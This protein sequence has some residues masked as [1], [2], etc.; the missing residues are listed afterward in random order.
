MTGNK[1]ARA[2]VSALCLALALCFTAALTANAL[3][4]DVPRQPAAVFA[5]REVSGDTPIPSGARDN[6]RRFSLEL[7]FSATSS[8]NVQ[9]AFGRDAE[10][11]DG[12]LAAEETAFTVG[13][14]SGGWF[15]R[16]EGLR[17][18]YAMVP[19]D[20]GTPRRRTLR[21]AV[22]VNPRVPRQPSSSATMR[23]SSSSRGWRSTRLRPG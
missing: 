3:T 13:W 20:G 15:L 14:D 9:V 17:A 7:A 6:L 19:A 18:R 5:D 4:L 11:L 2:E 8:N 16:P 21:A 12:K 1:P 10:P 23:A 22:R